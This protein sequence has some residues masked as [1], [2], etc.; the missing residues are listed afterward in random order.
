VDGAVQRAGRW[1]RKRNRRRDAEMVGAAQGRFSGGP[2]PDFRR[3]G[4]GVPRSVSGTCFGGK[5]LLQSARQNPG[6]MSC[7]CVPEVP[8]RFFSITASV[9]GQGERSIGGAAAS[10]SQPPAAIE[11]V[12]CAKLPFEQDRAVC[13]HRNSVPG[14]GTRAETVGR[15][16][17]TATDARCSR[18]KWPPKAGRSASRPNWAAACDARITCGWS[19]AGRPVLDAA[20]QDFVVAAPELAFASVQW[21]VRFKPSSGE[22]VMKQLRRAGFNVILDQPVPIPP[23]RIF[24]PMQYTKR[25]MIP[26]PATHA[27]TPPRPPTM[28]T[29]AFSNPTFR[30]PMSRTSRRP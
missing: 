27:C 25:I 17:S 2:F 10:K 14:A 16:D 30:T 20:R 6:F 11:S 5:Q 26:P 9:S 21:G 13:S 19:C 22:I 15:G 23:C 7:G 4:H 28:L 18:R 3:E 29:A 8:R 24:A 12:V 1:S